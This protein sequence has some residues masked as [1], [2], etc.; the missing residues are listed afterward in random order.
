MISGTVPQDTQF[1]RQSPPEQ[2]AAETFY[3]L[4]VASESRTF[5]TVKWAARKPSEVNAFNMPFSPSMI[6]KTYAGQRPL[7]RLPRILSHPVVLL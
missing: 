1:R 6:V 2:T 7:R 4:P 5:H 3:T